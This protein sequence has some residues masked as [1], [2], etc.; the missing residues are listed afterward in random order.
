MARQ[1]REPWDEIAD[2]LFKQQDA[3][4]L[5]TM[6]QGYWAYY[7]ACRRVGFDD[8]QAMAMVIAMQNLFLETAQEANRQKGK[9]D[10]SEA[11]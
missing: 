4:E 1:K 2:E 11:V 5:L 8:E 10:D 3:Q 7:V 9:I 6:A